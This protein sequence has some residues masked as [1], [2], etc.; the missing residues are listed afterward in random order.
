MWCQL[1]SPYASDVKGLKILLF[2]G[3]GAPLI[4]ACP[5]PVADNSEGASLREKCD[6]KVTW[7][8]KCSIFTWQVNEELINMWYGRTNEGLI[9]I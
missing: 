5:D 4:P 7:Q 3:E 6:M 8:L 9:C 2:W 1:F